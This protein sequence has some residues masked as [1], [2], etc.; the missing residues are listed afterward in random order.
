[1]QENGDDLT[2]PRDIE[3]TVA[4][5]QEGS[6]ETFADHFRRSGYRATVEETKTVPGL[7]WDVVVVRHMIP[8]HNDIS[9][10]EE[11]LSG[12]ASPLG[13]RNDG[14]GCLVHPTHTPLPSL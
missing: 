5:P 14:W 8:Q 11:T 7:P 4:F 9:E 2:A 6:A 10:F 12:F 1:M 3:F 13:G